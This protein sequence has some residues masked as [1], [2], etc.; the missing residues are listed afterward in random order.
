MPGMSAPWYDAPAPAT[1]AAPVWPAPAPAYR[2]PAHTA[3]G[4]A[5]WALVG[6]WWEP[7]K[8]L[9][10]V[11]LWVVFFPLGWWRSARASRKRAEQRQRRG[12]RG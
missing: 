1:P 7:A 3:H 10:R 12:Y 11:S 4:G 5:Y 6:W 9:G 2:G 8:W